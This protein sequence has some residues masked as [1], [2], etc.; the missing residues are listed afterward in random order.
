[1]KRMSTRRIAQAKNCF[2]ALGAITT[3]SQFGGYGLLAEGVM[4]AVIAEGELYLRATASMEPAF[5]ARGMVNMVYSKRGVPITLRYYWVDESLW[6]ER[7]ELV[8]LAWQAV[9]EARRE[10]RLKAGDHGRLKALPNIDVNMERLLWRAGIHNAYDLRL[11][12]AKRSY[13]CLLQQQTNLGLRVL[14]SLGGAIAGYH[15]AAL[16]AEL[17]DELVRWFDHMMAMRR[18]GHEPVIQGPPSGP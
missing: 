18:H 4:F 2:A 14:L 6:R 16:P 3:R 17:H 9:R 12:G 15:Q 11:Q 13:L 10:Q 1:M 5:R 7:N 8:G